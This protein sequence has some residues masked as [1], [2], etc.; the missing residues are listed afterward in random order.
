MNFTIESTINN[1]LASC[2]DEDEEVIFDS[3]VERF[4]YALSACEEI[5]PRKSQRNKYAQN[6][7][8]KLLL[9]SSSNKSHEREVLNI[10]V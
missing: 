8:T 4:S 10:V 5:I 3:E 2:H 6:R 9:P 7:K 1:I